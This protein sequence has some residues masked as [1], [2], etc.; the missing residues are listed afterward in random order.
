MDN[1]TIVSITMLVGAIMGTAIPYI[2]KVRED[3]EIKFSAIYF[4]T[5]LLN[6]LI[7]VAVLIPDKTPELTFKV[8]LTAFT[9]GFGLQAIIN[10]AVPK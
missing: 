8:I 2:L 1:V 7:Q 9:A 5:L 6:I 3:P 4:Y 10:K